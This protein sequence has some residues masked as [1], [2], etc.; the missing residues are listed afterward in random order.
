MHLKTFH[1]RANT[2][3]PETKW[4][5]RKWVE[6]KLWSTA[7]HHGILNLRN[8]CADRFKHSKFYIEMADG[9]YAER[10]GYYFNSVDTHCYHLANV[11]LGLSNFLSFVTVFENYLR[12]SLLWILIQVRP[13]VELYKT[14]ATISS[15]SP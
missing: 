12:I 2:F 4:C 9:F 13:N 14:A 6:S 3:L 10:I 8:R 1:L 5:G 15:T 7:C 11:K